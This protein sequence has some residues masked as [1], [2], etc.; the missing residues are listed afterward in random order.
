MHTSVKGVSYSFHL[1]VSPNHFTPHIFRNSLN[2]SLTDAYCSVLFN[3]LVLQVVRIGMD[4]VPRFD[5]HIE[6]YSA[7]KTVRDI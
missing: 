7:K 3:T 5:A 4:Q 2:I 6:I 1:E